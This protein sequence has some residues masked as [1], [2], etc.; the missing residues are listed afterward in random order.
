[1]THSHLQ[2]QPFWQLDS[3][4]KRL[5]AAFLTVHASLWLLVPNTAQKLVVGDR[6]GDRW[7]ALTELF[8]SPTLDAAMA[9]IFRIG[10]PGDWV[11]FAPAFRLGGANGIILQNV[12]LYA[13]SLLLLYRLC[14][15]LVSTATARLATIAW[16]VLPA[17]IFHPHALVS[18]G[19]A[20]PCLIAL[21]YQLVRLELADERRWRDLMLIGLT[22]AVLCFSRHVY[23]LLP[24]AVATWLLLFRPHGLGRPVNTLIPAACA[25]L[26]VGAWAV[27]AAIGQ[28]HYPL[29]KSVGGL[30]SNLYLRADRMA[31]MGRVPMPTSYIA[32]KTSDPEA[33]TLEPAEFVTF[34]RQNALLFAKTA[35]SDAFNLA[36]NPGI[37][38][39][40]GRYLGLF[41]LGEKNHRD[42][43]KWREAREQSGPLGVLKLLWSTSPTGFLFNAIGG[44]L[45]AAFLAAAAWGAWLFA[46][47]RE[48]MPAIRWLL[49]GIFGY[50]V[51]L[52]SVSAGYTRWDHRSGIEFILALW[53]AIGAMQLWSRWSRFRANRPA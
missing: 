39:L 47:D 8:A 20:N 36:V 37:A 27:I 41:D 11:M 2:S 1:M 14:L 44:L 22:L 6:A 46:R 43:N 50:A 23:L 21:A 15:M 17:T 31:A 45:W 34:A 18:E 33:S 19:I 28:A 4:S 40:A 7:R 53:F 25:F 10:S 5:L 49:F 9:T 48:Q 38:M 35:V 13:L 3:F 29:G 51:V 52:T 12:V 42:L 16:A 24:I 32:R 26:L 30:E